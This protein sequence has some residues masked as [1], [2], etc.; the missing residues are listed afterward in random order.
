MVMIYR[1]LW[2]VLILSGCAE[3]VSQQVVID[4]KPKQLQ[5]LPPIEPKPP[6]MTKGKETFYTVKKGD[7]LYSIGLRT[8]LGY[9]QI[10]EWNNIGA[11]YKVLVGQKLKLFKGMP[12]N[13]D[14]LI[15]QRPKIVEW[16][17]KIEQKKSIISN[18][19]EKVLKLHWQWPLHGKILRDFVTTNKKGIDIEANLGQSVFSAEEGE[20]VYSGSGLIGYGQLIII[21]HDKL[22]LSAYANNES[23]LVNEGQIV[24]QGQEIARCGRGRTGKPSLYFEI[25]KNGK[26]VDPLQFLPVR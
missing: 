2:V 10:A 9:W 15:E 1:L 11:N 24:A 16:Q 5:T 23:A 6:S 22:F 17:P 25:R 12:I 7:T 26:S 13:A 18:N 8:G 14:K 20:V 19:R 4:D 3:Q 21:K